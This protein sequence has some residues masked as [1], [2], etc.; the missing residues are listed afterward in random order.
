MIFAGFFAP[1]V[2]C[3]HD[4]G[5]VTWTR[6]AMIANTRRSVCGDFRRELIPGTLEVFPAKGFGAISCG[7]H[8]FCQFVSGQCEG[9]ADFTIVWRQ[10]DGKWQ[11]TRVL[12]YAHSTAP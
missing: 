12:R 6:E 4:S 9:M 11:I 2:A 5:G 1:D 8:R 10:H 3:Y 7:S